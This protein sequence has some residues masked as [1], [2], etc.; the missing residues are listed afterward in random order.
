MG[1]KRQTRERKVIVKQDRLECLQRVRQLR[2]S[3]IRYT[4]QTISIKFQNGKRIDDL[5]DDICEGNYPVEDVNPIHVAKHKGEWFSN[6]NRRLWVFKQVECSG[7]ISKIIV[8]EVDN[9]VPEKLTTKNNGETVEIIDGR[10]RGITNGDVVEDIIAPCIQT[11]C[12]SSSTSTEVIGET[13]YSSCK[14][15]R[16]KQNNK[17]NLCMKKYLEPHSEFDDYDELNDQFNGF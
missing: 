10:P 15:S 1:K 17:P 3:N 12:V 14:S 7:K 11:P 13:S 16:K 4:Q 8:V 6:D 5:R 9:I 2:P